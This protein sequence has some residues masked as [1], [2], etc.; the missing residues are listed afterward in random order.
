MTTSLTFNLA[1]QLNDIIK[2]LGEY[3]EGGADNQH[4]QL[5][6]AYELWKS[7]KENLS[8]KGEIGYNHILS[9]GYSLADI[10]SQFCDILTSEYGDSHCAT[11][12]KKINKLRKYV[13]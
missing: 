12:K 1:Q 9:G 4:K 5:R 13:Y 2:D 3:I 10:G 11:V 6:E 7:D 8:K